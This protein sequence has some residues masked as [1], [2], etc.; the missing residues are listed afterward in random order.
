MN[1]VTQKLAKWYKIHHREL[2][3]RETT[4]PYKIWL[5]EIILQQTR[6]EQGMPYYY[7]FV[8][9]YPTLKHL[10]NASI[11]EVLKLWQ[12]L[13]Y[14]S[15]ARNMLTAANELLQKHK[16]KFPMDYQSILGLKGV[17]DYTAAAIASLAFNL[18]HAV[19]DGNVYRVLSR[20]YNVDTPINSTKGKHQFAQYAEELLDRKNPGTHNQAMMELGAICCKPANPTC[21]ICPI[22]EHCLALA[23]GTVNK[24]PV[25]TKNKPVQNRYLNYL[26][27]VNDDKF[28]LLQRGVDDIWK[29]LYDL[30]VIEYHKLLEAD[31]LYHDFFFGQIKGRQTLVYKGSSDYVHKLT[32]RN[33]HARF[34]IFFYKTLAS[35]HKLGI[36]ETTFKN[37]QSHAIPRLLDKFLNEYYKED[38]G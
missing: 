3:W 35:L 33:L 9:Q 36:F 38:K 19:V 10:A 5:S 16:G 8:E 11:D 20:L 34:H 14:Y 24:L 27:L 12:G 17:G 21:H 4:D 25:K 6:V 7:K 23:N 37:M 28:C 1:T 30:P 13:G 22:A 32:H 31:E 18:P 2:P 15:R 29:G 26:F